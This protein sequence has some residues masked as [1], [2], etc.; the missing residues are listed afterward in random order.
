MTRKKEHDTDV[1]HKEALE[2]LEQSDEISDLEEGFMEGY[3]R[4][5]KVKKQ[6]K[7]KK[8]RKF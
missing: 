5:A 7:K 6:H 1:Y 2:E 4:A 8:P 3:D